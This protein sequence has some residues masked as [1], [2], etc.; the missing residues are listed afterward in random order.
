M[1][2]N[3]SEIRNL[4]I[5][6]CLISRKK[7][8]DLKLMEY[9]K[10]RSMCELLVKIAK[11]EDDY[12]GDAP[13]Q[14]AYYLRFIDSDLLKKFENELIEMFEYVDGYQGH[15]AILLGIIK[16]RKGLELIKNEIPLYT[17]DGSDPWQLLEAINKFNETN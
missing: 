3:E 6:T 14:A 10:D 12:Q 16:S 4:L 11:D 17:K 1:I 13:M 7:N 8:A 9:M 15:I 2:L 5:D